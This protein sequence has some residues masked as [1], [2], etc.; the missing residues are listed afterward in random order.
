M[1]QK[2]SATI[3]LWIE[4]DGQAA[5]GALDAP[6]PLELPR[7]GQRL[8]LLDLGRHA[9]GLPRHLRGPSALGLALRH[10]SRSAGGRDRVSEWASAVR[11]LR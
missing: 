8:E 7:P 4:I 10:R 3:T 1:G 6:A 11:E 5:A 2:S 9:H